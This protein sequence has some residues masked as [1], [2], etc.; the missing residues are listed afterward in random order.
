MPKLLKRLR[1]SSV[2]LCRRGANP[3]ARIA[4]KKSDAGD[5]WRTRLAGIV[6]SDLPQ[7]KLL[8]QIAELLDALRAG[9]SGAEA[10]AGCLNAPSAE[11]TDDAPSA[12]PAA[13]G[14]HAPAQPAAEADDAKPSGG[15]IKRLAARSP[16]KHGAGKDAAANEAHARAALDEVRALRDALARERETAVAKRYDGMCG[17]TDAL[18]DRLARLRALDGGAYEDYVK[19][20]DELAEAKHVEPFMKEYGYAR[21]ADNELNMRVAEIMHAEPALTHAQAVVKAYQRNPDIPEVL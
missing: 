7:D 1:I 21:R 4:L 5:D 6:N 18:A 2:D 17:D 3:L 19:L 12:A 13:C 11:D 16:A 15:V 8:A 20:L 14:E 10:D 9:R